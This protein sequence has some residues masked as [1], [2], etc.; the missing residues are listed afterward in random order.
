MPRQSKR[1]DQ[2]KLFSK[3]I[4]SF[5]DFNVDKEFH[6]KYVNIVVFQQINFYGFL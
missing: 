1:E 3:K 6:K 4:T 5:S 2:T